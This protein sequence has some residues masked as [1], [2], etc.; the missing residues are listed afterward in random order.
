M[1]GFKLKLEAT[2]GWVGVFKSK[3]RGLVEGLNSK[4]EGGWEGSSQN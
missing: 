3:F 4:L 1:G 2:R